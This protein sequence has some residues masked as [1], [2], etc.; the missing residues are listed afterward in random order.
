MKTLFD[1][2][3]TLDVAQ[4]LVDECDDINAKDS[5]GRTALHHAVDN[6]NLEVIKLLCSKGININAKNDMGWTASHIAAS[7]NYAEI[8]EFL[9][10]KEADFNIE[11][12]NGYTVSQLASNNRSGEVIDFFSSKKWGIKTLFDQNITLDEAKKHVDLGADIYKTDKKGWNALHYAASRGNLELV[13][14]LLTKYIYV[15]YKTESGLTALSIAL[16]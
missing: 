13:K 14:F 3:L 12:W 1:D 2:R 5:D 6:E 10:I 4:K 11:N 9:F 15:N 8:I 16:L 7:Y